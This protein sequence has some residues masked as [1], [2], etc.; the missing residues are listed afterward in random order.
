MSASARSDARIVALGA[1][2][3]LGVAGFARAA[4]EQPAI[5][6]QQAVPQAD[7]SIGTTIIGERDA[8][9]GLYLTPWKE[10][11]PSDIDRPPLLFDVKPQAVD[12]Q[13]FA[14]RIETDDANA[15]Y[16]RVRVE[17]RL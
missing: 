14:E 4:D 3:L 17:P 8:A 10:E 6:T 5:D 7:G 13:Q 12:G 16:R 1:A 15:A 11:A 9:V 2:L